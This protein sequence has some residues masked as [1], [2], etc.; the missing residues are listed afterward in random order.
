VLAGGVSASRELQRLAISVGRR[1]PLRMQPT[2]SNSARRKRYK[3][4]NRSFL[5]STPRL[6]PREFRC[7][8]AHETGHLPPLSAAYWLTF[9]SWPR[10]HENGK[11]IFECHERG[12]R[13]SL[14]LQRCPIC[15]DRHN[16]APGQQVQTP[17]ASSIR[18]TLVVEQNV[19]PCVVE[20]ECGAVLWRRGTLFVWVLWRSGT[21]PVDSGFAG[22]TR[23][24]GPANQTFRAGGAL[25]L[26]RIRLSN[27]RQAYHW[28]S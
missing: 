16:T 21:Q 5:C 27:G 15:P 8:A 1:D 12:V 18:W 24:G 25:H 4:T 11:R 14:E 19:Y 20:F 23:G 13:V 22:S 2:R 6:P 10:T 3:I 28:G 9:A 7:F 26:R 17:N